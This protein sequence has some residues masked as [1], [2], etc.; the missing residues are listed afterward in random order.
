MDNTAVFINTNRSCG[1]LSLSPQAFVALIKWNYD[2]QRD[3]GC[4]KNSIDVKY[5]S[6]HIFNVNTTSCLRWYQTEAIACT[7]GLMGGS[8]WLEYA[9]RK[10]LHVDP[11]LLLCAAYVCLGKDLAPFLTTS[12]TTST[13]LSPTTL[14]DST[15]AVTF[16][17]ESDAMLDWLE[18]SFNETIERLRQE[19]E[20]EIVTRNDEEQMDVLFQNERF[21]CNQIKFSAIE[22]VTF[23]E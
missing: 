21:V 13:T 8:D 3:K 10:S 19:N 22:T 7:R 18:Q 1:E 5:S 15:A 17:Y 16:Y 6:W 23:E 11:K 14:N 2:E 9:I 4:H 20:G 12:T